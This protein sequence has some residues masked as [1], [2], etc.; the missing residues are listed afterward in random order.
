MRVET[1]HTRA[2]TTVFG[3]VTVTRLAYRRRGHANLYPADAALN[4]PGG[5]ALARSAATGRARSGAG[6]LRRHRRTRSSGP[7]GSGWA[8]ARPKHSPAGPRP[9]STTSTP[10]AAT[11]NRAPVGKCWS[12]PPTAR[13]SSCAPRRC[14]RPPPK[15]P[16]PPRS[17]HAAVQGRETQPQTHGRGRR[18]LRR[19]PGRAHPRRHPRPQRDGDTDP[20]QPAEAPV[21]KNKWL[22]AS[23]TDDA[24]T[25]IGRRLRRGRPPRPHPRAYLDR[26]GRRQQPPDRPDPGRSHATRG[27]GHDPVRLHPRPGV[28]VEGGLVLLR[29]GRPRRRGVG[30]RQGDRRPAGQGHR[31]AAGLRRAATRRGWTLPSAPAP[32][33]APPT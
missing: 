1:G 33:P 14:A 24:A 19:R 20:E 21:A 22:T 5:E 15:P 10:S 4:L 2:L 11:G 7:P 3:E 26:A 13:A 16:P 6:L 29:G 8:N 31:V 17:F 18:R 30:A 28:P 25:V 27:R 12:C 9:T 32:T 23:V